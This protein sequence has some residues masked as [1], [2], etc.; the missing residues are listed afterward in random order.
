MKVLRT[1]ILATGC[2]G[3]LLLGFWKITVDDRD[4]AIA[5]LEAL[6]QDMRERL[7]AREAMIERLSRS[8]RVAH[9][10]IVEQSAGVDGEVLET[11]F[12]FI[13]L[14]DDG[15]ELARQRFTIPGNVLF[16]DA[17]TVKFAPERVAIGHPLFGHSLVL[18]R[19][20]YSDRMTPSDGFPIDTPGAIP[21]GYAAGDLGRFEQR[22][23]EHFWEIA[24]NAALAQAMGVR[25]AQ[26]EA[27]YKPVSLGQQ[28]EVVVDATGGMSLTPVA[29]AGPREPALLPAGD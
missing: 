15:S 11:S 9:V 18:L 25:V 16:I 29:A 1:T 28:F 27:V 22:L 23:W 24:T 21:P 13:E 4:Q 8:L 2:C 3:A 10:E 17:W 12:L 19:R 5:E 7:E 26:G 6:T 14:D 20:V